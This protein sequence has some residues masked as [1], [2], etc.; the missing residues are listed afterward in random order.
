MSLVTLIKAS[1]KKGR[2][3]GK[4]HVKKFD[5]ILDMTGEYVKVP[6]HGS[7]SFTQIIPP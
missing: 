6:L 3:K 5:D 2:R 1:Q 7:T 4:E